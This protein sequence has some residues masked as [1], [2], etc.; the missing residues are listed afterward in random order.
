M[1]KY[2]FPLLAIL[3]LP[4][5]MTSCFD[6]E[7]EVVY[8]EDC[9]IAAFSLGS[10]KRSL[11]TKGSDGLDSSYTTTFTG[12][13]FPMTIDQR[14]LTIENLDSLPVRTRLAAVLTSCSF[15]GILVWRKA[16]LTEEADTS[17]HTY[18]S[19]DSLDLRDSLHLRVVSESGL[20]GRTY[21]LKVNVHQ[22]NGDSTIW[23][24]LGE[25]EALKGLGER[26][27][28]VWNGQVTVLGR[29]AD[30]TMVIV[31]HPCATSGE[32]NS[33]TTTGAEQAVPASAQQLGEALYMTT[34]DGQ[35]ITT[36]DGATWTPAAAPALAGLTLVAASDDYLYA[37]ADGKLYRGKGDS[38]E[39]DPL[40]D[41]GENLPTNHLNS[42]FYTMRDG[43]KRIVLLGGREGDEKKA[44]VWAKAWQTG[45]EADETWI[46][47]TPN[48]AD[49]YRCPLLENL[50]VVPYDGGMQA[51]GGRSYD[52]ANEALDSILHSYDHGI[53]WKTYTDNDMEPD[54]D[55]QQAARQAQY[56]TA[57]V[58]EDSFLW[59]FTDER[60]WRGRINRLGF[61]RN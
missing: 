1:K 46:Y 29:Q 34:A 40:D 23:N 12:T 18:S 9:Y 54:P 15:Q 16:N 30:G 60:V 58:D 41:G 59:V 20:S 25:A 14:R 28:L 50:C 55:M 8:S 35:L 19:S 44:V 38:W 7:E 13:Y 33:R 56:I 4:L 37:M 39:E 53:T 32:W 45:K 21:T 24:N 47:Y 26:K 11:Y 52:G 43:T 48:G 6:D 49:K 31:Q 3:T 51:L 22:Q 2:I 36:T 61:L 5:T 10:M 17:W 57:T 42:A 27:A